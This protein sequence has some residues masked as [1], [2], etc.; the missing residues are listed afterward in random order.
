MN[1]K[2]KWGLHS[3]DRDRTLRMRIKGSYSEKAWERRKKRGIHCF[4]RTMY[5]GK[6]MVVIFFLSL[7]IIHS[8]R[9]YTCKYYFDKTSDRLIF[10]MRRWIYMLEKVVKFV[11]L[12]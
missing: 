12:K 5:S 7:N 1:I 2:K 4:F 9:A 3:H 8:I 11:I 6:K 10:I